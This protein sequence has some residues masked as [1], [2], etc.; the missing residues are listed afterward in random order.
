MEQ[1]KKDEYNLILKRINLMWL[2]WGVNIALAFVGLILILLS[3]TQLKPQVELSKTL[4]IVGGI[5]VGLFLILSFIFNFLFVKKIK[6]S[7]LKIDD[8]NKDD[9]FLHAKFCI[10]SPLS[11]GLLLKSKIKYHLSEFD[12]TKEMIESVIEQKKKEKEEQHKS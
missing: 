10:T 2:S 6:E 1:W 9:L 11:K 8:P 7:I 4:T 5:I 3:M 12:K